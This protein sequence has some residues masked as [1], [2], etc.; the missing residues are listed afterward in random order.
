MPWQMSEL[1]R[2]AKNAGGTMNIGFTRRW[3]TVAFSFLAS[4][5]TGVLFSG[6]A[7]AVSFTPLNSSPCIT[8]GGFNVAGFCSDIGIDYS[9]LTGQLVTSVHFDTQGVPNNLDNVNRFT[10]ARNPVTGLSGLPDELKVATVR[11]VQGACPQQWPVGTIFTGT[12]NGQIVRVDPSGF[13]TTLVMLPGEAGSS[14]RGGL[15]HDR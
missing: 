3:L 7:G 10:G 13:A 11:Q 8:S 14:L 5:L 2:S 6:M 1:V 12:I 9:Q 15:F 4:M